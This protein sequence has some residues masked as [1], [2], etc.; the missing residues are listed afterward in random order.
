[1]KILPLQGHHTLWLY[2]NL[3]VMT[4][5]WG[6]ICFTCRN[7]LSICRIGH[8][9][10]IAEGI[11]L[12][13][14]QIEI[15]VLSS[16]RRLGDSVIC[17]FV[18]NLRKKQRRWMSRSLK[19]VSHQLKT[20]AIDWLKNANITQTMMIYTLVTPQCSP[21]PWE[22]L[23]LQHMTSGTLMEKFCQFLPHALYFSL[24]IPLHRNQHG[25]AIMRHLIIGCILILI[26]V[27]SYHFA[28]LFWSAPA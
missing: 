7:T 10:C 17:D 25:E 23:F 27:F 1:M 5:L 13:M 20:K 24:C 15:R 3:I 9:C 6:C 22:L 16:T 28:S 26:G 4:F 14:W 18:G 19:S 12:R 2:L 11:P 8:I 21:F